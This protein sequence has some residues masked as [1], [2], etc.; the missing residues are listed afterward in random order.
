MLYGRAHEQLAGRGMN[1]WRSYVGEY[2]TSLV[3]LDDGLKE[4]F[5]APAEIAAPA[6][7]G[8]REK[9]GGAE[10]RRGSFAEA[11]PGVGERALESLSRP[12]ST[13][14]TGMASNF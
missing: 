11:L 8:W 5:S 10:T 3:K 1:V 6:S 9:V 2:C 12:R 14:C 4:P 7:S 13:G